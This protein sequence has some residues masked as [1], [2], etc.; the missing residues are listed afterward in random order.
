MVI[1]EGV[2]SSEEG[3]GE[4]EGLGQKAIMMDVERKGMELLVDKGWQ[5]ETWRY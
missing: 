2:I 3:L 4:I 5:L 1:R